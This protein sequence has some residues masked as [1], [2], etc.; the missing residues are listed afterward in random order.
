MQVILLP[1]LTAETPGKGEIAIKEYA[2]T[3]QKVVDEQLAAVS[4]LVDEHL[5]FKQS[6]DLALDS[7]HA[8]INEAD[9]N[10]SNAIKEI[11]EKKDEMKKKTIFGVLELFGALALFTAACFL[12]PAGLL[13]PLGVGMLGKSIGDLVQAGQLGSVIGTLEQSLDTAKKT[14]ENLEQS[15]LPQIDLALHIPTD[16]VQLGSC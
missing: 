12:G 5:K 1:C 2:Q 10:M 6:W 4:A 9:T 13:A 7:L 3:C 14:K 8:A 15:V 11:E 16:F